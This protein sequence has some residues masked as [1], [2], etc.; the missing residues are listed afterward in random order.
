MTLL[1]I[2][3]RFVKALNENLFEEV[4]EEAAAEEA[5]RKASWEHLEGGFKVVN[6]KKVLTPGYLEGIDPII[7][8]EGF[9]SLP[10]ALKAKVQ[11]HIENIK[12]YKFEGPRVTRFHKDLPKGFIPHLDSARETDTLYH[13]FLSGKASKEDVQKFADEVTKAPELHSHYEGKERVSRLA[14]VSGVDF[15]PI[16]KRKDHVKIGGA[17]I[18]GVHK[19]DGT[20]LADHGGPLSVNRFYRG[21]DSYG[22]AERPEVSSDPEIGE[23]EEKYHSFH[24]LVLLHSIL[25]HNGIF[26]LIKK[27]GENGT[28]D[29]KSSH[30]QLANII[31]THLG[32]ENELSKEGEQPTLRTMH[33]SSDTTMHE[34]HKRFNTIA[35]RIGVEFRKTVGGQKE[36]MVPY[37]ALSDESKEK[38]LKTLTASIKGSLPS[39]GSP[40]DVG[41][42]VRRVAA[43]TKF[44]TWGTKEGSHTAG[45]VEA[46]KGSGEDLG[47]RGSAEEE[48]SSDPHN[49]S[50]IPG[51]P[52]APQLSSHIEA[53]ASRVVH[54]IKSRTVGENLDDYHR[55]TVATL[56][57]LFDKTRKSGFVTPANKKFILAGF[58]HIGHSLGHT[59]SE[60]SLDPSS[61]TLSTYDPAHDLVGSFSHSPKHFG[62][63]RTAEEDPLTKFSPHKIQTAKDQAKGG[64]QKEVLE[65]RGP[66][67]WRDPVTNTLVPNIAG[68]S[69]RKIAELYA[70]ARASRAEAAGPKPKIPR[71]GVGVK[72]DALVK[73]TRSE[74]LKSNDVPS[75][76]DDET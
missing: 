67:M 35:Q 69:M 47:A 50:F 23:K 41:E 36:L 75:D 28:E 10:D 14:T 8:R 66:S 9:E 54:R 45:A 55:E 44:K 6:G 53:L 33:G 74:M 64:Q 51:K 29:Y 38:R 34:Y 61:S 21:T 71:P 63:E 7:K 40:V 73:A 3:S 72:R 32:K 30:K 25:K 39:T 43:Q 46:A 60:E 58:N 19:E 42:L 16:A 12:K 11:V 26:A 2:V 31:F 68:H 49:Y 18:E 52:I 59:F 15:S 62:V 13:N 22:D 1:S 56:H 24:P 65:P 17:K 27:L 48:V 5:A 37:S 20:G 57:D 70:S 4:D 76:T